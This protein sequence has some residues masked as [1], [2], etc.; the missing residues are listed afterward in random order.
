VNLAAQRFAA[1]LLICSAGC[2]SHTPA[3]DLRFTGDP[4]R[5]AGPGVLV[6][7]TLDLAPPFTGAYVPVEQATP[8]I[9]ALNNRVYSGST[10]GKL[11]ALD[12][13]GHP[14]YSVD[15]GAGIEAQPVADP[16]RAEVYVANVRGGVLALNGVDGGVRWKAEAGASISQPGLLSNDALYVVTDEDSVIAF[17]RSD[18]SVLWRYRREP[19]EGFVIAGHAG[20]TNANGKLLTGFGDGTVVALDASD[21]RVIWETDTSVDLVDVEST[22]RFVDVDTTPAVAGDLVYVASFSGGLY[23]LELANGTVHA[24]EGDLRGITGVTA[25]PDAL[26]VSSA[27]AGVVCLELPQLT[28]RWRH[29]V[30]RGAAGKTEVRDDNVYFAES[31]GA[32]LALSLAD[33]REM[34]RLESAHG[35]TAPPSFDGRVGFV[36]SNAAKLFSFSY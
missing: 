21:G 1:A 27:E 28:V 15:A 23:A 8:G 32:L 6:R 12:L 26:I 30:D 22:Q 19:H 34:G 14:V 5:G 18:G 16:A 17:S 11:V 24:H 20:L 33:G 7:W 9:D 3:R 35:F 2:V 36:L 25:T 13:S 10:R 31:L 4:E 29:R